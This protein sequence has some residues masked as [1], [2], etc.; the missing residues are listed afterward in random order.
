M[1]VTF[2]ILNTESSLKALNEFLSDKSYI[3]GD[4]LTKDDIKVY[5]AILEKSSDLYTNASQW[6]E[7]VS[8]KLATNFP[9]NA[10]GVRI[11]GQAAPA[12]AAPIKEEAKELAGMMMTISIGS[13]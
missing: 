6:Y 8:S 12:E 1:A 3:F 13:Q 5:A 4:Q 2:S 10:I 7:S 11:G 9:R